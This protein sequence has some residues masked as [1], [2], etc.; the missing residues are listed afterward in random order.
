MP[1]TLTPQAGLVA[2]LGGEGLRPA[3]AA[4]WR[5]LEDLSPGSFTQPVVLPTALAH[6]KPAATERRIAVTLA[7]L[8][9]LGIHARALSIVSRQDAAAPDLLA[10]LASAPGVILAGG[11]PLSLLET[12]SGT[13]AWQAVADR[14]AQGMAIVAAG[15]AAAAL[16]TVTL[17]PGDPRASTL[18]G[19]A[20]A[21]H[22]GL[23][24]LPGM[25]VLPYVGWL[26]AAL[27]EQLEAACPADVR[28]VGID[29]QAALI[30]TREGWQVSGPGTVAVW[31]PGSG[32]VVLNPGR[33]SGQEPFAC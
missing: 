24:L 19:L 30:R 10:A 8:G 9:S 17:V 3:S 18:P 29:D 12:L 27:V 4:L 32:R 5:Q 6:E 7:A 21:P 23:G 15:G 28:L 1:D 13:L 2:L 16:G 31:Q 22:A 11:R 33:C 20:L 14:H 25:C 26:Q